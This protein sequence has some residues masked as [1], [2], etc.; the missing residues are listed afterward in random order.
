MLSRLAL[1][2]TVLTLVAVAGVFGK[3]S[4]ADSLASV[5]RVIANK[6]RAGLPERGPLA[7]PLTALKPSDHF[8]LE[9]RVRARIQND[10]SLA[11]SEVA[12]AAGD[13]AGDV[14][15]RGAVPSLGA[16]QRAIELALETVGVA[17]VTSDELAVR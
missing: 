17:Q 13:R 11:G 7:G 12:V 10:K 8:P 16:K 15:L 5:G 2:V 14:R 9:E 3:R 4:D 6:A 1:A